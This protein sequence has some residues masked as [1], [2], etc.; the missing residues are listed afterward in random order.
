[1]TNSWDFEKY[2]SF[3]ITPE[4]NTFGKKVLYNE[5]NSKPILP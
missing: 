1:M 4:M 5:R 3:N 2:Q